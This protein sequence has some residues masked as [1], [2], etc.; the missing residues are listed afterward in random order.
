M[1]TYPEYV[2]ANDESNM[3]FHVE[4]IHKIC[5]RHDKELYNQQTIL[6]YIKDLLACLQHDVSNIDYIDKMKKL[7]SNP[8]VDSSLY[9]GIS[10]VWL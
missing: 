3:I 9:E 1:R 5:Y 7:K 2:M 10:M 8:E 6:F 4:I